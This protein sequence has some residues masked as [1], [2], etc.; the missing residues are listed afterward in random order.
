MHT[1]KYVDM[2]KD[3]DMEKDKKKNMDKDINT[4]FTYQSAYPPT[5]LHTFTCIHAFTHTYIPTNP[6]RY[7]YLHTHLRVHA[8]CVHNQAP[9]LRTARACSRRTWPVW[10]PPRKSS[11]HCRLSSTRVV[12]TSASPSCSSLVIVMH[13]YMHCIQ[14]LHA[15]H[16]CV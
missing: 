6:P 12:V 11:W 4:L 5:H 3:M 9:L 10:T 1:D 13:T 15:P 8:T 2:D 16:T 7:T 14:T